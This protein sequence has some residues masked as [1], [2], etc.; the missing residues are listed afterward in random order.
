VELDEGAACFAGD[1][2][3]GEKSISK[4]EFE[5]WRNNEGRKEYKPSKGQ[6]IEMS[7]EV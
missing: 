4:S 7:K 3:V 6:R 5:L 1:A 2:F